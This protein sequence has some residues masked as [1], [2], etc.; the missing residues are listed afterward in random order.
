[1]TVGGE[2]LGE[3]VLS[4]WVTAASGHWRDDVLVPRRRPGLVDLDPVVEVVDAELVEDDPLLVEDCGVPLTDVV[5]AEVVEPGEAPSD[6]GGP[7]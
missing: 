2:S 1:M 4:R 7:D 5:D 6:A 3:R